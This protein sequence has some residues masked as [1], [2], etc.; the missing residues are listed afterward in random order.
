MDNITYK[1]DI[2]IHFVS[3]IKTPIFRCFY[4]VM[5]KWT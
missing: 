5:D 1:M 4:Y 3:I 2:C